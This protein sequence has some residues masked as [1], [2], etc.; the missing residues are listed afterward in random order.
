MVQRACLSSRATPCV[1]DAFLCIVSS[2]LPILLTLSYPTRQTRGD[3]DADPCAG[4]KRRPFRYIPY[5]RVG[6]SCPGSRRAA[7][8]PAIFVVKLVQGFERRKTSTTVVS[9]ANTSY[10]C[11]RDSYMVPRTASD[12]RARANLPK[13]RT[14][15]LDYNMVRPCTVIALWLTIK[16]TNSLSVLSRGRVLSLSELPRF[17]PPSLRAPPTCLEPR[18]HEKLTN[19]VAQYSTHLRVGHA[20]IR[21]HCSRR[22]ANVKGSKYLCRAPPQTVRVRTDVM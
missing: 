16:Y 17:C 8:G 15:I 12:S 13:S 5:H 14:D 6:C 18:E 1:T 2:V 20:H 9:G 3:T 4:N 21:A 11:D 7:L 10:H 22:L 19:N